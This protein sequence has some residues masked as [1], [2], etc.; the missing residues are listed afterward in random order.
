MVTIEPLESRSFG[1]VARWLSSGDLNEWL[2]SEWR[3]R[4]IE[5]ALIAIA[6]RNKRNRLFLVR[7]DGEPCGLVGLADMDP[8]DHVAMVW[9]ALGEPALGGRGVITN[10]VRHL[11]QLAFSQLDLQALYAWIME[12]NDR[13]RRVLEKTGFREAGRLRLATRHGDRQIDR[14]YFD[15]TRRDRAAE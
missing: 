2:T 15:L 8:V 13:S 9:Y 3:G 10:A 6:V 11:V 12:D 4:A 1:V 14:V 5:P 7:Y